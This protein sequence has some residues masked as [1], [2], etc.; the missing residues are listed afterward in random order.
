MTRAPAP[1]KIN[2][3]LVVGPLRADGKHEVATVYQRLDLADRVALE[4]ADAPR[5]RRVRRATR[6]SARALEALAAAAGVEPP[7]APGSRSA[8]PV[9]AGLGGGSS[10]AATALRA[11]ERDRSPSRCPPERLA[12]AR[13]RLGADVPFFLARGP[14]LGTGD[15]TELEPLD[16]PQDYACCSSCRTARR[17]T[18]PRPSTRAFD[19]R[20][21][22]AGFEDAPRAARRRSRRV[23]RAA[24]LA[25]LPPNDLASSPL[26]ARARARSAPSAPTSA[27]PA[28]PSTGS[29]STRPTPQAAAR[30]CAAPGGLVT[31]PALVRLTRMVM[32]RSRRS[33]TARA[34]RALAAR[35]P[36][37]DRAL[38]RRDR[39]DPRPRRR[40][41]RWSVVVVARGRRRRAST[42]LGRRRARSDARASSPGSPPPRSARSC[43]SRSLR[44]VA[45]VVRDHRASCSSRSSRWSR[46]CSTPSTAVAHLDCGLRFHGA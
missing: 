36:A 21:G 25:A 29:S 7:G 4:P 16:L 27:A 26:A 17:S 3:A 32:S 12:R 46:C 34:A 18:R 42:S 14:Q 28:R 9:A 2:L 31:T 35:R 43:S 15:G 5:G 24:D 6:S 30:R 13:A 39:G 10:D 44:L 38:D 41:S 33:S 22:A 1:A 11:R 23:R 20:D 8:I 19:E 37:A 45:R 40:R